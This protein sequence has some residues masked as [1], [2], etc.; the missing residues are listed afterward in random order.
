MNTIKKFYYLWKAGHGS[1][2]LK[3]FE[4]MCKQFEHNCH[5]VYD[6][7]GNDVRQILRKFFTKNQLHDKY[8]AAVY[9]N[10]TYLRHFYLQTLLSVR[11]ELS[12]EELAMMV[13]RMDFSSLDRFPQKLDEQNLSKM[14]AKANKACICAY[15]RSYALPDKYEMRLIELAGLTGTNA[16]STPQQGRKEKSWL[17][18]LRRYIERAPLPI[19]TSYPPQEAMIAIGDEKLFVTWCNRFD[20]YN[21]PLSE[22]TVKALIDKHWTSAL[23]TLLLRSFISHE[24]L[25]G[26]LLKRHPQLRYEL[27]FSNLRH[28]LRMMEQVRKADYYTD[29][30][31]EM[32][33][34]L[35]CRMLDGDLSGA[36][37]VDDF[38]D[39]YI[40]PRLHTSNFLAFGCSPYLC[41][42]V[43]RQRPD[44]GELVV[45]YMRGYVD[46][47][48]KKI[49]A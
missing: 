29:E 5:S 26:Y 34:R 35:I 17:D 24:N 43:L 6:K 41:A 40:E 13:E 44:L 28:E 7:G 16:V 3:L 47:C 22:D 32:D 39:H 27:E 45:N 38:I 19:C 9:E 12:N 14:F 48:R 36:D 31:T 2:E 49:S 25:H 46:Y 10:G 30:P 1:L 33:D 8:L 42:V 4:A 11:R 15:V 23:R 20:S 37:D 21:S 18:V